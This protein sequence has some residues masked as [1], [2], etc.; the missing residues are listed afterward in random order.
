MTTTLTEQTLPTGT[1]ALDARIHVAPA[2]PH[3]DAVPLR[4]L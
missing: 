2:A 3:P 1:W 4:R